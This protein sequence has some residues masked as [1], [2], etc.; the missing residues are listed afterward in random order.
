MKHDIYR[1]CLA[2]SLTMF[3]FKFFNQIL[4]SY[5]L[6]L[7]HYI[8][9]SR[10]LFYLVLIGESYKHILLNIFILL[11]FNLY[12]KRYLEPKSLTKFAKP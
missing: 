5:C 1:K 11:S 8:L 2:L 6:W 4:K 7:I 10:T 12:F 9:T 3:L